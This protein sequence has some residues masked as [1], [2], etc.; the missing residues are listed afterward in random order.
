M[1]NYRVKNFIV[2]FP[3]RIVLICV[4]FF[5]LLPMFWILLSAFK[6]E[7]Q[8]IQYPPTL[9]PGSFT[10]Y[11]FIKVQA[12]INIIRYMLNS[13]IY[14][15]GSVIPSI[16]FNSLAGYAFARYK[17]PGKSIIFMMYLSTMMI[18]FQ[19]IMIPLFL[20]VHSAGFYNS[21]LGL[22]VPRIASAYWIFFLRAA[23]SGLPKELEEAAR[24]DGL[25]EFGIYGRIMLPQIIPTVVTM[26]MLSINGS[27][28]D[29]LWPLLITSSARMRTIANGLALF[30]GSETSEYG[31]AFAG[32]FL[33]LIPMLILFV[34]GQKYF[35]KG[36]VTSGLKG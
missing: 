9:L 13:I 6:P 1:K 35:V 2:M 19:V 26:L 10:V 30:V 33:S 28:N 16:F 12:R 18:P 23:F 8:M 5:I 11:N 32:C 24:L 3:V 17:F 29:L 15:I 14:A 36:Q 4:A 27:W 31:N 25:S 34:F 7:E 20:V 21:Y 22:I